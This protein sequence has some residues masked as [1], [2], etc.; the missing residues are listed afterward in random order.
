MPHRGNG[1]VASVALLNMTH[2]DKLCRRGPQGAYRVSQMVW[3][4]LKGHLCYAT[5]IKKVSRWISQT[6]YFEAPGLEHSVMFPFLTPLRINFS[7][8]FFSF[9]HSLFLHLP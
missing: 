1:R 6:V 8:S 7:T 4:Q 2:R 9:C 3:S 5:S